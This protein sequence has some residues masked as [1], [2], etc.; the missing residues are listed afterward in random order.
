MTHTIIITIVTCLMLIWTLRRNDFWPLVLTLGYCVSILLLWMNLQEAAII[1]LI[2]THV[3]ISIY[4]FV[5][6]KLTISERIFIG[7]SGIWS[8]LP[9]V[10]KIWHL[11]RVNAITITLVIPL[12]LYF[13]MIYKGLTK[14]SEFGFLTI[15]NIGIISELV[16]LLQY[17][18][19]LS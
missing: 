18:Y 17:V 11:P 6:T 14:K 16:R 4:G 19:S 13:I 7:L 15:L 1:S 12:A 10:F 9:F 5:N 8:V 2:T 3:T